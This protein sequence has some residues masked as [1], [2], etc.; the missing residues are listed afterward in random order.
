[1]VDQKNIIS[2]IIEHSKKEIILNQELR[3]KETQ[4]TIAK[5]SKEMKDAIDEIILSYNEDIKE[6]DGI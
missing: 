5:I 6:L 1:M 3:E 2:D 4:D